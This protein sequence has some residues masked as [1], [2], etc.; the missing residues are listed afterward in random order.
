MS[1]YLTGLPMILGI[2]LLV[3]SPLLLF[4]L[5]NHI[6]EQTET[7]RIDMTVS[8]DGYQVSF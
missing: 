2:I 6:G 4:S 1:K 3:L 5:L 8:L 7:Q